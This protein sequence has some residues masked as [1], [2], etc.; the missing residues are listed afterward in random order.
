MIILKGGYIHGDLHY[1]NLMVKKTTEKNFNFEGYEIPFYGYQL[2]AIDYESVIHKKFNIKNDKYEKNIRNSNKFFFNNL[3]N[4]IIKSFFN[5]TKEFDNCLLNLLK[6]IINNNLNFYIKNINKYIK[7]FPREEKLLKYIYE[8]IN[9][10]EL[11]YEIFE[12]INLYRNK[13]TKII[14]F[15]IISEFRL[16]YIQD[17]LK[18]TKKCYDYNS[19]LI[20]PIKDISELFQINNKKDLFNFLIEKIEITKKQTKKKLK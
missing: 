11:M 17:N 6:K 7:Y 16:Y 8:N 15:I 20:I 3:L 10:S 18:N 14:L 5:Y 1:N 2:I 12:K 4:D 13:I 19:D 9:N